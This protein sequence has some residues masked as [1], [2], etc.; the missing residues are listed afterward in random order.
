MSYKPRTSAP[1]KSNKYFYSDNPFY[2]SGYGLPNCTT[3]AFG[4]FYE[5]LGSMPKLSTSNAENWYGKKDGYKRGKTPKLGAVICWRKGKAGDGSDGAGH[6]AIVEKIH[7][8]GSI[9]IS[10]SGWKASKTMW[11]QR[12]YPPFKYG[13][14]YTFQGFI[15][16]PA[17][18]DSDCTTRF[19]VGFYWGHGKSTDGSYDPGCSY[20]G[21]TEAAIVG[22]IVKKAVQ[23]IAYNGIEV[24]SD[25]A[26]NDINMVKQVEKSNKNNVAIHVALHVDWEK[27]ASGS[28]P[29]CC[30]GSTYGKYLAE[31]LDTYVEGLTGL[32]SKGVTARTDLYELN[33]TDMPACIYELGS[34]KQDADEWDTTKERNAYA[35]ALAMG[36]CKYFGRP[37]KDMDDRSQT[38][39][40][41]KPTTKTK[42]VYSGVFPTLP[43]RGYFIKGD[44]GKNV[45]YLQKFLNWAIGTKLA[46]DGK[47]GPLTVAA[48]ET[49]QEKYDLKV[50]GK[51]GKKSLA[52]AKTI[53]R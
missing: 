14:A 11:T 31:C 18:K 48:V 5:T 28:N 39:I 38:T 20:K 51:F 19:K 3:W 9:T 37:F 13:S 34:I 2:K 24:I 46:I 42:K 8:D 44:S 6:V 32:K 33:K 7:E 50:D 17:V 4:R 27:S 45:E 16:N 40:V 26:K 49:F 12:L 47:L 25:S 35:K 21:T 10:Q 43:K 53:K 22:P 41:K 1:S 52:K 15:Y 30:K 29:L 23:Y 36:V